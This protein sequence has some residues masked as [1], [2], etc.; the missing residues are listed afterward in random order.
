MIIN[1]A[2]HST[3]LVAPEVLHTKLGATHP[4]LVYIPPSQE[5]VAPGSLVFRRTSC[6]LTVTPDPTGTDNRLA[7]S[8]QASRRARFKVLGHVVGTDPDGTLRWNKPEALAEI[9]DASGEGVFAA[10]VWAIPPQGLYVWTNGDFG[11]G[12]GFWHVTGGGVEEL[13]WALWRAQQSVPVAP[14]P[15][16]LIV[17]RHPA[18]IEFIREQLPEF[19]EAPVVASATPEQVRDAHV[20]GNLPLHLAALAA[21]LWAVEFAGTPPRG[22]EYTLDDMRAAGA[23]LCAYRVQRVALPSEAG[24]APYRES[25]ESSV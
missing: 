19:A 15:G 20:A 22:Q 14:E 1:L 25:Q 18:A 11:H 21:T 24:G 5:R 8:F 17:S 7:V 12:L 16:R 9:R 23:A 4:E 6:S 3:S 10:G 2:I 13:S